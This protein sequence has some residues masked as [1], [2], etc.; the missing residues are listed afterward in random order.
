MWEFGL[1]SEGV[2]KM[3][4]T[5]GDVAIVAADLNLGAFTDGFTVG[6]EAY[7]HGGF[8]A[9]VA[10]GFELGEIIGEGE[11][12][13]AAGKELRLEIGAQ[14]VAED[15]DI[16]SVGYIG[17]LFDLGAG[18]ELGFVYE[19]AGDGGRSV[20]VADAIEDVIGR[21]EYFGG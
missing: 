4:A 11:E 3:A 20:F 15:G 10:D 16:E 6:A 5:H 19:D 21:C 18:E 7:V 1:V 13:A 8:A 9:A 12:R 2:L 14:P 17:E